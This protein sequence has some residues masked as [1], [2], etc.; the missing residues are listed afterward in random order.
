MFAYNIIPHENTR[1][2]PYELMFDQK[3]RLP[4]DAMFGEVKDD[5]TANKSTQEYIEDLRE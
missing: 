2:S 1:I 4:I 3:P 5:Y